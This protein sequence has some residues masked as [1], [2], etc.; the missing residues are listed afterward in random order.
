MSDVSSRL[1][2]RR[3]TE[4][5]R[6]SPNHLVASARSAADL[7]AGPTSLQSGLPDLSA[8]PTVRQTR[9]EARQEADR[10]AGVRRLFGR[11]AA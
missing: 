1:C 11:S 2:R 9:L 3:R 4:S 6:T 8:G 10:P 7:P 5:L